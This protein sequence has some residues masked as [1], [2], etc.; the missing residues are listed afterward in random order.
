LVHQRKVAGAGQATKRKNGESIKIH[1]QSPSGSNT[2]S[3]DS[4]FEA[5]VFS[6]CS[7]EAFA[8]LFGNESGTPKRPVEP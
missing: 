1:L 2:F 6:Y 3:P 7:P 4:L 5:T 8:F